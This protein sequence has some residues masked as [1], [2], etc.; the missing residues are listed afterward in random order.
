MKSLSLFW[1]AF[2]AL[3]VSAP[4]AQAQIE[5]NLISTYT[6]GVFDDGAT[7]IIAYNKHNQRLYSTNGSTGKIDMIDISNPN[8]PSLVGSIDLSP[9]GAQAN[10]VTTH[11]N[12]VAAAVENTNKQ[13]PGSA[14]FFDLNGNFI[15]SLAIGSLP[16]NI[17]TSKNGRVVM[18]AC[19]GE[20][21]D[22]FTIDPEGTVAVIHVPGN[23]YNINQACVS[24]L[25]FNAFDNMP[26]DPS[27]RVSSNPGSSTPSQDFE[28]EYCAISK[29][30]KRGYVTLQE[31]NAI[32]IVDLQ[33]NQIIDVVGL[34]F[35]DH[36]LP[37]NGFDASNETASIDITTHP[38]LGMYQPD[39]ITTYK[40]YGQ[41]FLLTANEGDSRDYAGY[42]EEVRVS[43][44]VLDPVAYPNAAALQDDLNLGRL[45]TTTATGDYDNDGDIDQIYSY[46]TRSFS[47]WDKWGNLVWDSGDD[48]EQLT[49]AALPIG[50][51]ASN[52][53]NTTKD[54]SD[55]KGPEPEAIEVAKIGGQH[56]AFI[57]LERVGGVMV[58]NI[59]NP[60]SP[61][62]VEYIN[63]RDFTQ[64]VTTAG[65][66]DLGP[67]EVL[68][69]RQ[70]ASPNGQNMLVV[71]NEVS[72]SI[73][74]YSV[75][76]STKSGIAPASGPLFV[77][78]AEEAEPFGVYPNPSIG[79]QVFFSSNQ[80]EVRVFDLS[81]QQVLKANQTNRLDVSALPAGIYVVRNLD[82]ET[83]KLVRQ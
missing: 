78:E 74:L 45:K 68:F 52:D 42:S 7:E 14:V 2:L 11:G 70:N 65:A 26:L 48:F 76:P 72:G 61:Q 34:G 38:T 25:D 77:E 30:G 53:D 58:Y 59:T 1:V 29:N 27:V 32:A 47:I 9:Y 56:Y 40:T 60:Y 80:Q 79:Q 46:G 51:N 66:L 63:N 39:A 75:D 54:R 62:F 20:P 41:R 43:D 82:G 81:G 49:A 28:P 73:S 33:C 31:N 24:L 15:A 57:G 37:G 6:T 44:L 67:E 64:G 69:I 19:E 50:F 21:N 36:S 17:S 13:A 83:A 18:V 12:W 5:L 55:D 3:L 10:S 71:S 8:F 22:D 35:K 16:D 4:N 23:V